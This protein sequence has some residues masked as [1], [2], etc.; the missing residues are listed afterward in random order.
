MLGIFAVTRI[1]LFYVSLTRA[2]QLLTLDID[3]WRVDSPQQQPQTQPVLFHLNNHTIDPKGDARAF[4]AKV[5]LPG[6]PVEYCEALVTS[7]FN[8]R[9]RLLRFN[10]LLCSLPVDVYQPNGR[11]EPLY[12]AVRPW[13]SYLDSAQAFAEYHNLPASA[14]GILTQVR[15]SAAGPD[16]VS[17]SLICACS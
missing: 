17:T 3:M 7:Q 6:E 2:E 12:F 15:G 5:V 13:Q 14:S 1:C 8:Q 10:K 4:C 11:I 16:A 9:L